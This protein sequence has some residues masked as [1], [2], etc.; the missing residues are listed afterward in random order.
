MA[1]RIYGRYMSPVPQHLE[2]RLQE[3][4]EGKFDAE[5]DRLVSMSRK[6]LEEAYAARVREEAPAESEKSE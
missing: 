6:E 3:I 1:R 2:D 4:A 5:L